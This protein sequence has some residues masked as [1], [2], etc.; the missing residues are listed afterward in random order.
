MLRP[1]KHE[2][3]VLPP[4]IEKEGA[5]PGALDA[6]QELLGNDLVCIDIRAVERSH[7]PDDALDRFHLKELPDVD[8]VTGDSGRSR[9]RRAHQMRAAARTLPAFEVSVAG[10]SAALAGREDVRG[11]AEAPR[12]ARVAPLET[13]G[14]EDRV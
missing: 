5:V 6:L 4:V 7:P 1:V 14:L 9:H 10:R 12:A 3:A 2:V 13:R 11:H 8:E